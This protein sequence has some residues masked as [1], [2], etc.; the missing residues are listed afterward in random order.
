MSVKQKR[1]KK[2]EKKNVPVGKAFIQATYN[3]TIITL[4][5]MQ[6]NVISWA[7]SGG[8]GFKGSRKSTPFAAQMAAKVAAQ[9]AIDT[10]GLRTVE[11]LVKGPGIGREA[12][13]RSLSQSG[14]S[15]TKIKDITPI[16][17]NGCRPPKRRRV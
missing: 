17:H 5:D 2:K 3:N 10:A 12:A 1:T 14:L 8:E 6:G 15:V 16:P 7:S 13:I 9:K 11:V 4:T